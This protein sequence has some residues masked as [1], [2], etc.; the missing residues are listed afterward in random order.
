MADKKDSLGVAALLA[1]AG[2]EV[3]VNS[4]TYTTLLASTDTLNYDAI[5]RGIKLNEEDKYFKSDEL[6]IGFAG[7]Q[8]LLNLGTIN[9]ANEFGSRSAIANGLI[10][11][12]FGLNIYVSSNITT[13]TQTTGN[14]YQVGY[15]NSPSITGERPFGYAVKRDPMIEKE[16]HARGR[17]WDIVGH[18][19][20]QFQVLH[21]NGVCKVNYAV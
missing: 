20:Y 15:I 12:L 10:G 8:H 19:E 6:I 14:D 21:P 1:G 3:I 18:E 17:F 16:Y 2:N 11:S 9:K 4:K 7:K 13:T 5:T